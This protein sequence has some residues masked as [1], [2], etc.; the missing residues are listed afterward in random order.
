[1]KVTSRRSVN[2]TKGGS[3]SRPR[4]PGGS[5]RGV[6][7][8]LR[9]KRRHA[10]Y[11]IGKLVFKVTHFRFPDIVGPPNIVGPLCDRLRHRLAKHLGVLEQ[12]KPRPLKLEVYPA[13]SD[14]WNR[15]P[16]MTIVTPSYNQAAFLGGTIES[17]LSQDYPRLEYAVVDG[18]SMDG[19]KELLERYRPRLAYTVS[20]PDEGQAHAIVK[21]FSSILTTAS[22]PE[23]FVT[24]GATFNNIPKWTS[25]TVTASSSIR[26]GWRSAD[27]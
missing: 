11:L 8:Y 2:T 20:E 4:L 25:S 5:L 26:T 19:S 27:G 22:C 16:S 10:Q 18:D 24:W 6:R 7:L 14:E 12:H 1:M 21:G 13:S 17:V 23:R 15:F 9:E 3:L